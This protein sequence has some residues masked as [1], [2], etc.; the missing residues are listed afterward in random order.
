M[1]ET[2]QKYRA[3]L[4]PIWIPEWTMFFAF[5]ASKIDPKAALKNLGT[6][7]E[8]KTRNDTE[9]FLKYTNTTPH[10]ITK[11]LRILFHEQ[12]GKS[13]VQQISTNS[14]NRVKENQDT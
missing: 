5:W 1:C 6:R 4:V 12:N 2:H 7:N 8:K 3:K 14:K 9:N 13:D 11:F 10:I